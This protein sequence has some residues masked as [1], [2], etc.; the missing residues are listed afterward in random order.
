MIHIN[1][2]D[3]AAELR[4]VLKNEVSSLKKKYKPQI[5][6]IENLDLLNH[7]IKFFLN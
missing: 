1:G 7:T 3:A 4:E 6:E 5:N 2:K